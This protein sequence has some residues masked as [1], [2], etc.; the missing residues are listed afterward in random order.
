MIYLQVTVKIALQLIN[1]IL[2]IST[3]LD[4]FVEILSFDKLTY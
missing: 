2:V 3:Y 1:F 4:N